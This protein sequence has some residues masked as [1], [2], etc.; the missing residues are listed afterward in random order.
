MRRVASEAADLGHDPWKGRYRDA[1]HPVAAGRIERH[2]RGHHAIDRPQGRV[3]FGDKR[4][5]VHTERPKEDRWNSYSTTI[6]KFF[7]LAP[8]IPL[9]PNL[10]GVLGWMKP[11][12]TDQVM[13]DHRVKEKAVA[14]YRANNRKVCEVILTDRLRVFSVA[15]GWGPLCA[16]L[17]VPVPGMPF[18]RTNP[19]QEFRERLGG[20]PGVAGGAPA[21]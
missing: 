6:G 18:P 10:Q 12:I 16:F 2:G 3:N 5:G 11:F 15:E 17:G 21:G 13:G 14:P 7:T 8:G 20:E 19:R 1:E 9:P 4:E